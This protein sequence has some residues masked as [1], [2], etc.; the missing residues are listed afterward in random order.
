MRWGKNR[1]FFVYFILRINV[2]SRI[3]IQNGDNCFRYFSCSVGT[4]VMY[5]RLDLYVM[6]DRIWFTSMYVYDVMTVLIVTDLYIY[7]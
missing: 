3:K 1:Y 5:D 7:I 6:Y 2:W 4:Y